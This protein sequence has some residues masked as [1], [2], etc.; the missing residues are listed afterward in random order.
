MD[1]MILPYFEQLESYANPLL[2]HSD[3]QRQGLDREQFAPVV[4]EFYRLLGWDVATGWPT[5]E[6]L[7]AVGL[8]DVCAPMVA[9]A[10]RA[11]A[12]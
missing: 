7:A 1:E 10:A 6:A 9:G 4:D 5:P 11:N 2:G 12:R 8:A 3:G